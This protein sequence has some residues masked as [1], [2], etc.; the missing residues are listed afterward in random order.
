M[1]RIWRQ[2]AIASNWPILV[3][4]LVLSAIG[5]VCILA[6]SQAN[7]LGGAD[8]R[9]QLIFVGVGVGVMLAMQAIS[10]VAIGRF[11]WLFYFF[12]LALLVYTVMPGVPRSGFLGV[13]EIKG[14]ANWINVGLLKLQPSELMKVA[15]CMV[16][17]RYLRFRSNY[18]TLGGL[19]P[20]FLLALIPL[21]VILK[22]PDLGTAIIFVP[23]LFAIMFVAG[24]RMRH[25]LAIMGIGIVLMPIA[26][27]SGSAEKTGL[28]FEVPVLKHFPTL[29]K[30]YQRARVHA[31]FSREPSVL[32]DTGFQQEQAVTAIGSGGFAGK[33]ALSIPV[34]RTVPESH[35]DMIFALI[36]E[37]FGFIGVIV[38][39]AAYL[40]LFTTG[41]EI[42][43]AT[44]EPFGRLVVIGTVSILAAETFVN[45]M[46]SLRLFPV[47][48]IALPFVSYGGSSMLSS[49]IAAGL[50][51]NIGQNRP[52]V[53]AKDSFEFD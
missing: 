11:A 26:W 3:A 20:P 12:S 2:L 45:I 5:V 31:M 21:V 17:A 22:Q 33:G 4:V 43:S 37:Q 29:I 51:L 24:A 35:N 50:L 25:L 15:F 52:L 48:G 38:T 7:L 6:H 23:A 8:A 9:K 32:R 1:N 47:T 49:F 14:Q 44:R 42:A 46:V 19:I 13:P 40:V 34:G 18:R 41:V 28:D 39:L 53:M 30:K 27:F 36:G 10:Y 16:M